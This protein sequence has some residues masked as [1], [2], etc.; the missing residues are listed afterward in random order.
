MKHNNL[1][2]Y[3]LKWGG[4]TYLLWCFR[5]VYSSLQHAANKFIEN[6][7]STAMEFWLAT[8][9][10]FWSS[11]NITK[12]DGTG[13]SE[14]LSWRMS[15]KSAA[16]TCKDC[17]TCH[18]SIWNRAWFPETLV[19]TSM[20]IR[21][22]EPGSGIFSLPQLICFSYKIIGLCKCTIMLNKAAIKFWMC[23]FTTFSR[24]RPITQTNGQNK[25]VLNYWLIYKRTDKNM[26]NKKR[27]NFNRIIL[28]WPALSKCTFL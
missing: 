8:V 9:S 18:E 22:T 20:H 17:A 23:L 19:S 2:K 14:M 6:C 12:L 11:E 5:T 10:L 26:K 16:G 24:L 3:G 1:V 25:N 28:G 15:S 21:I 7:R 4:W 27:K 13:V